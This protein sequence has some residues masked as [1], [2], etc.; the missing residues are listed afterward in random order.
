MDGEKIM[1]M[2]FKIISEEVE[3]NEALDVP[4]VNSGNSLETLV[5]EIMNVISQLH[6]FHLLAPNGQKHTALGELYEELQDEVDEL[7]EIYIGM[8]GTLSARAMNPFTPRVEYSDKLV[9]DYVKEFVAMI[10]MC[11]QSTSDNVEMLSLQDELT[12]IQELVYHFV[13]K[14]NLG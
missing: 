13:Y 3:L 5:P 1:A 11:L 12:E 4:N 6:I 2:E 8:G 14:F 10:N 9:V 7:A